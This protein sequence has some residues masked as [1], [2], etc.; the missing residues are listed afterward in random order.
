[1]RPSGSLEGDNLRNDL[2]VLAGVVQ[3]RTSLGEAR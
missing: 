3:L 2:E 1:M